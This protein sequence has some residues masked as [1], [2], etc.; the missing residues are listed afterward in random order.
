MDIGDILSITIGLFCLIGIFV[1]LPVF[2]LKKCCSFICSLYTIIFKSIVGFI[3]NSLYL[4]CSI[5]YNIP[6]EKLVFTIIFIQILYLISIIASII[7]LCKS[8]KLKKK[9][10]SL[11]R[12]KCTIT[13][14]SFPL[15]IF[16]FLITIYFFRMITFLSFARC[17]ISPL[18]IHIHFFFF[19]LMFC[20]VDFILFASLRYLDPNKICCEKYLYTTQKKDVAIFLN[21]MDINV[22]SNTV[23]ESNINRRLSNY[24]SKQN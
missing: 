1:F 17:G 2:L 6:R 14:F 11:T 12:L 19:N 5:Y 15:S 8:A 3:I 4:L 13:C 20:Y 24:E 21:N 23:S 16:F 22:I 7:L 9:K 10:I 18:H